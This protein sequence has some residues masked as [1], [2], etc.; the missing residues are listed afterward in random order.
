MSDILTEHHK[1]LL[2]KGAK[3]CPTPKKTT[4][5]HLHYQSFLKF[6]EQIRWAYFFPKQNDFELQEN[7]FVKPPWYQ[8]TTKAAPIASFAVESFLEACLR[9]ITQKKSQRQSSSK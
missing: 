3:F 5:N 6:Q 4:D 2:R 9:D 1:S 8:N 7:N